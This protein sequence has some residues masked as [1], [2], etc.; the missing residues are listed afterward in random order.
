MKRLYFLFIAAAI[1]LF[2]E[3]CND[4]DNVSIASA[5][6][7]IKGEWYIQKVENRA[8]RDGQWGKND[9]TSNYKDWQFNF[10]DNGVATLYIPEEDLWLDGYWEVYEK[11]DYDNDNSASST[12]RLYMY[13]EDYTQPN[14]NI[15]REFDLGNLKVSKTKFIGME[16]RSVGVETHKYYYEL[17]R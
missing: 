8:Q 13:F 1:V 4:L 12:T 15:S 7:R 3:S 2:S 6:E 11:L 10:L 16:R 9:V 5:Q 17:R 14:A